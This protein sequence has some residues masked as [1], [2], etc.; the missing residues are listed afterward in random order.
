MRRGFGEIRRTYAA[1]LPI[2]HVDVGVIYRVS[3]E[4]ANQEYRLISYGDAL[5][6]ERAQMAALLQHTYAGSHAANPVRHFSVAEWSA[7]VFPDDLLPWGSFAVMHG[8]VC[9]AATL[10]HTGAQPGQADF[11][12]RGV[13]EAYQHL[14]RPLMTMTTIHQI[15]EARARG[16]TQLLLECDSTDPWSLE[17]LDG[18]PFGPAPTWI[19]L[20]RD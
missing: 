12:W 15:A 7:R 8:N 10:L 9:I 20:R 1:V 11:G 17:V 3:E 18:F 6:T 14:S 4:V 13:A 16:L 5:L 2:N 19:T